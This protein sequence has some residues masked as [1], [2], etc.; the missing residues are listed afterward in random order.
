MVKGRNEINSKFE[1]GLAVP[2][3]DN[4]QYDCASGGRGM[5]Q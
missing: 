1:N 3:V 4:L 5:S 2:L